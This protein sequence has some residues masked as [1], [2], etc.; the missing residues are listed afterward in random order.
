MG[1]SALLDE[2][3]ARTMV[4]RC[5]QSGLWVASDHDGR[6]LG[7]V[8]ERWTRGFVVTSANGRDLGRHGTLEAAK[9]VLEEW[10]VA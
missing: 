1:E 7:I 10:V 9:A 5:V 4:W 6:A 2:T 3:A 8:S